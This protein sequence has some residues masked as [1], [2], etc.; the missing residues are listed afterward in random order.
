MIVCSVNLYKTEMYWLKD[1]GRRLKAAGSS[2]G[3]SAGPGDDYL[4][5]LLPGTQ[6]L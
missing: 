2:V 1:T 4:D 5:E 3:N 6:L